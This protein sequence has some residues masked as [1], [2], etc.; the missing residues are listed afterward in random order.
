M[1][2]TGRSLILADCEGYELE[3]FTPDLVLR[4]KGHDFLIETHDFKDI[5]ITRELLNAFHDTHECEI[6]ESINDI[7]K[8]Y[9]YEYDEMASLPLRRSAAVSRR[10]PSPD[11]ALDFCKIQV[12]E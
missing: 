2:L 9:D 12:T 7:I 10:R 8:A 5:I 11:H 3:L 6:I 1:P 4:L